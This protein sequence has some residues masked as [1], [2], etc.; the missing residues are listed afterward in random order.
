M[1]Y[2]T[3]FIH[4]F[5]CGHSCSF[6]VLP[7]GNDAVVNTEVQISLWDNDFNSVGCIFQEVGLLGHMLVL[8][9]IFYANFILLSSDCTN[10][11]SHQQYTRTPF[12]PH[13]CQH[14]YLIFVLII[15]IL[16]NV[17]WYIIVI[18]V[19]IS[20]VINNVEHFLF[21]CWLCMPSS[22]NRCVSIQF[23]CL[24]LFLDF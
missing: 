17:K 24:P 16:T 2:T 11:L 19:C 8:F 1:V 14:V 12:S 7:I 5:I 21:P 22:D 13:A 10:L 3:L 6:H 23:L 9:L 4:S 20:L 15:S 18:L